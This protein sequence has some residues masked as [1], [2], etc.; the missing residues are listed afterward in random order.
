VQ[1][2]TF[3]SITPRICPEEGTKGVAYDTAWTSRVRGQNGKSLF[4]ECLSWII[5]NQKQD[6]SWGGRVENFQDRIISTLSAI[7]ALKELGGKKYAHQISQGETYIWDHVKK[8]EDHFH[9]LIG[10]ELLYPSLMEQAEALG[11]G[12]PYHINPFKKQY[13]AKLSKVDESLWY[14]PLV[15]LSYSLE[16][17][18]DRVDIAHLPKAQLPNGSVATSPAATAFY[19]RHIKSDK[20]YRYLK[21]I[22]SLTNDGSVMTVYPIEVFEYGWTLYNLMLAGLYFERYAEICDFLYSGL[23]Q[24][25][26]GWSTDLPVTDADDTALACRALCAMNY[27]VDFKIFDPY[28]MRDYYIA[29]NF[30]LDPS[31]STN[32]HVLDIA[33]LS[34]TF[35]DRENVIEKLIKFLE[36]EM[37][38]NG[39][40]MDKWHASPYYTTGHAIIA[41]SDICPSLARKGISWILDS[42]NSNGTW[43]YNGGTLEE[44]AYA[45]Q[46]LMHYHR[47]V[48]HINL[49][50]IQQAVHMLSSRKCLSLLGNS[51][52]LWI[53][54]VLYTPIRVVLSLAVSAQFMSKAQY[55]QSFSA[56]E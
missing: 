52:E 13:E 20:A 36:R 15:T 22:L 23:K 45:I 40:W 47:R 27:P 7:I 17:L 32:I 46:A 3:E 42:M 31:V 37:Q 2:V 21:K 10:V 43:G 49:E 4:P 29:F 39:Y 6:G 48:E 38:P 41:L 54:K 1:T 28:A 18:N 26:V 8:M 14:S 5:R 11:L 34:P 50:C 19:L 56:V 44:T 24:T 55:I 53:G 9:R 30:E 25:G 33:R 12:L 16:F 51:E 35:P